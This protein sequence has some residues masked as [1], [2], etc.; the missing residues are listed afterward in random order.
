MRIIERWK[1]MCTMGGYMHGRMD[2]WMKEG[3]NEMPLLFSSLDTEYLDGMQ[4]V[5]T[6]KSRRNVVWAFH[7]TPFA[8]FFHTRKPF[9][10][11]N[12]GF[13]SQ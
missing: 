3:S 4:S 5:C 6:I 8:F 1:D 13:S 11:P 7:P 12:I 10:L 2:A 9:L